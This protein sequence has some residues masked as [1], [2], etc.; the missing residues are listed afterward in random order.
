MFS[1]YAWVFLHLVSPKKAQRSTLRRGLYVS[2]Q[3]RRKRN[4]ALQTKT[5]GKE[6]ITK[7]K[8]KQ[9]AF[10]PACM[11]FCGASTQL[12]RHNL[13]EDPIID[14]LVAKFRKAHDATPQ[15]DTFNTIKI[16]SKLTNFGDTWTYLS[17]VSPLKQS[18]RKNVTPSWRI[19]WQGV[20]SERSCR[21]KRSSHL[22]ASNTSQGEPPAT[23]AK[24]IYLAL[25]SQPKLISS[26]LGSGG[27]LQLPCAKKKLNLKFPLKS[28]R[29]W[30]GPT[31]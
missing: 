5:T 12:Q 30:H 4:K 15:H 13:K 7:I 1:K 27:N 14:T 3:R 28:C 25:S 8:G 31:H 6:Q 11:D 29:S 2:K 16:F 22:V 23:N 18:R 10:G 21:N 24:K 26:F 17:A 20:F 19:L 9:A